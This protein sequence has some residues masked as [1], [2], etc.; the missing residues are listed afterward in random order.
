MPCAHVNVQFG[1]ETFVGLGYAERLT[2]SIPPWKLPFRTLRWGRH[3][4]TRRSVV[5]IDWVGDDTRRYLWFDGVEQQD[6]RLSDSGVS[7]L[8]G[9]AVLSW[10]DA[11]DVCHRRALTRVT[12]RLPGLAQRLAGPLAA[13]REHKQLARS[14]IERGG[15]ARDRGW[16]LFETVTW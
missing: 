6:A 10:H 11:R 13:M 5:W 16:T 1:E 8:G 12:L 3:T 2:L 14:T 4:S 15:E 7:R 9:D